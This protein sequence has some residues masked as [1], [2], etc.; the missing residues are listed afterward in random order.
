MLPAPLLGRILPFTCYP[1][2]GP[3]MLP[4]TSRVFLFPLLCVMSCSRQQY[5]P[6]NPRPSFSSGTKLCLR[7]FSQALSALGNLGRWTCFKFCLDFGRLFCVYKF[8]LLSTTF[9]VFCECTSGK[10]YISV[11]DDT[12]V[13]LLHFFRGYRPF[14]SCCLKLNPLDN[15]LV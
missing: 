10:P 8:S 2:F 15:L 11:H 6:I 7:E 3:A 9:A 13:C 5:F 1:L 12:F 14:C 4:P